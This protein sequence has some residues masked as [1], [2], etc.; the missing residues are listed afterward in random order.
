M[1]DFQEISILLVE[2]E[3]DLKQLLLWDFEN[4]EARIETAETYE[5][6]K[7]KLISHKFDAIISDVR[8]PDGTGVD[9]FR[10]IKD[11]EIAIGKKYFMTAFTSDELD[12]EGLKV[13]HLFKK[14]LKTK[15]VVDYVVDDLQIPSL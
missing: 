7:L 8:L 12:L 13:D 14:P 3:R 10:F 6:A 9:L 11:N 4:F 5:E 2:D 15:D 1:T